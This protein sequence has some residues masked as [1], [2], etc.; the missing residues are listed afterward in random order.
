LR[1]LATSSVGFI[2]KQAK[3]DSIKFSNNPVFSMVE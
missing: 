2:S 3:E 1:R